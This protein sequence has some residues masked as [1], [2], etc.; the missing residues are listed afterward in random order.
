MR[1]SN[2]ALAKRVPNKQDKVTEEEAV[3]ALLKAPK[4]R[5]VRRMM[6][7]S[8]SRLSVQDWP[9]AGHARSSGKSGTPAHVTAW[10][11]EAEVK[12]HLKTVTLTLLAEKVEDK[13]T[14]KAFLLLSS[15]YAN[16]WELSRAKR[17][18]VLAVP[19]VGRSVAGKAHAYLVGFNVP[20]AW[21][22]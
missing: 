8:R 16:A 7:S 20:M 4:N 19:G 6:T 15:Q 21:E 11:Q 17:E 22:L 3:K 14:A 10:R 18:E 1:Q 9:T 13:P 5:A 12:K 2:L